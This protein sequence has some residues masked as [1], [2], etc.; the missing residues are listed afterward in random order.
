MGVRVWTDDRLAELR[1]LVE[2]KRYSASMAAEALGV[3][4]NMVIG[5]CDRN[6]IK[7][8]GKNHQELNP[9]VVALARKLAGRRNK[10]SL[11][12]ISAELAKVGHLNKNG[13]PYAAESV[14]SMLR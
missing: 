9:E 2:V 1:R 4:R 11:R 7:L 10:P 12:S 5:A 3:T 8:T 13:K 14:A 6:D